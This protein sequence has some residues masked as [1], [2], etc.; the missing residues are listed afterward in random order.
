LAT[1]RSVKTIAEAFIA[2]EKLRTTLGME[3]GLVTLDRDGM[4]Y[5]DRDGRPT[6]FPVRE[7]EVYD[8]TGAGD[9]VL[10]VLGVATAAGADYPDAIM[11][12]NSAGGLE[13]ER[14]GVA[15]VKRD[16]IVADLIGSNRSTEKIVSD[17]SLDHR[18]DRLRAT[19]RS[20]VFTNGCFDLLHAGHVR[21]LRD[22]RAQG[23][24]LIVGVNADESVRR[25]NKGSNRPIN[26][27][28]HRMEVL[29]ELSCVDLVCAFDDDTPARLIERVRPKVLVKG[30]DYRPD[31]VVGR[32]F[33]ESIGGRLYLSPITPGLSTTE[34]V[35]RIRQ[36]A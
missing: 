30:A 28:E 23:D 3:V 20:I 11:I 15:M 16:E 1:G 32:E 35:A 13:V 4:A 27:L 34:T 2:A 19:R 25:L 5:L 14:I 36:A 8:I 24:A 29:A 9:M 18:L 12:A 33:V 21:Y 6:H 31:Q 17:R 26:S 7:R 10:A 22:A